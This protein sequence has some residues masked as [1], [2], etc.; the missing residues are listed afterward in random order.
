[1]NVPLLNEILILLNET[2]IDSCFTITYCHRNVNQIYKFIYV[3]IINWIY[4][5]IKIYVQNIKQL[6]LS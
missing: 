4:E 2:K 3:Y 1:M 5:A 6:E